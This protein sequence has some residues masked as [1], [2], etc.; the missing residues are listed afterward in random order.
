MYSLQ[1][2]RGGHQVKL[3][4]HAQV[5]LDILDKHTIDL[6]L[7]DLLLPGHNGLSVL[8]EL[9]SYSDWR[10]V[11]IVILSSTSAKEI[12]L[13][14]SMLENLGVRQYLDKGRLKPADLLNAVA[15]ATATA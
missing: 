6:V 8:Y 4:A 5:A 9:R 11:P 10:I 2:R 15:T 1:L 12:G 14:Q 7:L 3:A 13:D